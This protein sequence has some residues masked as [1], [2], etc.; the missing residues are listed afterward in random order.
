[1]AN[2][3]GP[4]WHQKKCPF[5]LLDRSGLFPIPG[6]FFIEQSNHELRE[7]KMEWLVSPES[8]QQAFEMVC[9]F[10]TMIAIFAS[11]LFAMRF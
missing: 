5:G 4:F 3:Q 2:P 7:M 9:C 10:F 1:L 11:Y 8:Y 6:I